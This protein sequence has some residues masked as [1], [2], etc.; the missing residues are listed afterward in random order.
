MLILNPL[1]NL[2]KSHAKKVIKEKVTL[3]WSFDFCYCVQKF[4]PYNFL[5]DFLHFM[6]TI[7]SLWKSIFLLLLALFSYYKTKISRN[8][9]TKTKNIC[10]KC[11]LESH[12]TSTV[13][14]VW[15]LHFVKKSK[16][17]CT[18]MASHA[19]TQCYG[20]QPNVIGR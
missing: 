1:K 17:R 14:L 15:R 10:Y 13:Y 20:E 4:S 9:L 19:R 8:G 7:S 18:L 5:G 11:V 16:N 2:Q 3:K 6:I 12:Y